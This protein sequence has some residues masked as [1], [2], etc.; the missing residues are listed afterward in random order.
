MLC[1][2]TI[3]ALILAAGLSTRMQDFKPLMPLCG[4]TLIE[5]TVD[6]VLQSGAGSAVVVTGYRADEVE[7]LLRERYGERVLCVKNEVYAVTDM[8]ASIRTGCRAMP[9]C[10]AFFLLPGDMPVIRETTF[11]ALLAKRDGQKRIIFPTLSG[12]RKHPPLIDS[13]Y[14]PEILSFYG[15]G[16][17]RSLWKRHEDEI[18][19]VP[20]DDVGIWVDLDTQEQYK[21]CKSKYEYMPIWKESASLSSKKTIPRRSRAEASTS[22]ITSRRRTADPF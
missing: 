3:R 2:E 8:L 14:I 18:V 22:V 16:G 6:S 17:L 10:D 5:N 4:K 1:I 12:Y 15:E 19:E 20:V 9:P 21:T 11:R 13:R 7:P